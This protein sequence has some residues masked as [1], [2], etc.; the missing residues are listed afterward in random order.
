MSETSPKTSFEVLQKVRYEYE[1]GTYKSIS[2]LA[3]RYGIDP[4]SLHG[5]MKREKWEEERNE[6]KRALEKLEGKSKE[7]QI[8]EWLERVHSRSLKDWKII[9]KSLDELGGIT[10]NELGEL[11]QVQGVDPDAMRAYISAR[12]MLDDMA[13]RALGIAEPTKSLDV[14]TGGKSFGESLAS[15]IQKVRENLNTPTLSD[16]E[17]EKIID[18][19]IIEEDG[20][21]PS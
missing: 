16:S 13:R 11:V 4:K 7:K 20:S 5:R 15:A 10:E 2:E 18:A 3:V 6:K 19:E 14:T 1:A 21:K 9:D 12:K 17:F 8:K